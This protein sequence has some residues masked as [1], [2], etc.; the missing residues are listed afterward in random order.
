MVAFA[1]PAID[2]HCDT[3]PITE[4][5]LARNGFEYVAVAP[6]LAVYARTLESPDGSKINWYLSPNG[7][8]TVQTAVAA[9]ECITQKKWS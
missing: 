3:S 6:Q 4:Y 1:P 7:K 9:Y 5:W 8:T 2:P